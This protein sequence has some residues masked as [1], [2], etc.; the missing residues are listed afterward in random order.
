MA[1]SEE[2]KSEVAEEEETGDFKREPLPGSEV[3]PS[4]E[5]IKNDVDNTNIA[6]L[7][8]ETKT[9]N[10]ERFLGDMDEEGSHT[11]LPLEDGEEIKSDAVGN[12]TIALLE[13]ETESVK[14]ESFLGDMDEDS[15]TQLPNASS[16]VLEDGEKAGNKDFMGSIG[17]LSI[18]DSAAS[19]KTVSFLNEMELTGQEELKS[20]NPTLTD[21]KIEEYEQ[22]A[23]LAAD[24]SVKD[25][26]LFV[27]DVPMEAV[28]EEL[29]VKIN[30]IEGGAFLWVDAEILLFLVQ[31]QL[32]VY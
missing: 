3:M 19:E 17:N 10:Q 18:D 7:E 13:E 12:I 32:Q 24:V 22:I 20:L 27:G 11:Q 21:T 15:H 14:Q 26:N 1:L 28:D 5:E 6:L 9:V 25:T 2:S 23:G 8:A 16:N 31:M 29:A 4:S 30:N